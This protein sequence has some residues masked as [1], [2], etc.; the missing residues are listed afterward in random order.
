MPSQ[1]RAWATSPKRH[2]GLGH[3]PGTRVHAQEDHPAG[4][5][6]GQVQ[7]GVVGRAGMDQRVVDV[8]DRGAEAERVDR[9]GQFVSDRDEPGTGHAAPLRTQ[10]IRDVWPV[11]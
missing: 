3:A 10:T 4:P 9:P 5:V 1:S 2:A 8:G 11:Q 6:A 7:I